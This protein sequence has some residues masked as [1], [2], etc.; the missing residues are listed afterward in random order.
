MP[1]PPVAD[2]AAAPHPR[3]R[4]DATCR[5]A[6]ADQFFS[7]PQ[8][9]SRQVRQRREASALQLCRSCP[10]QE[11]CLDYALTVHEPYGI[12]GGLTEAQRRGLLGRRRPAEGGLRPA[13]S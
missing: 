12:W 11:A 6:D 4:T 1:T 2:P 3:W 7:P 9:E 8:V 10:V 5:R 13:R